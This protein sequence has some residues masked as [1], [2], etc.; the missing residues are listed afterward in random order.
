MRVTTFGRYSRGTARTVGAQSR[1]RHH[2][3]SRT[4]R[5]TARACRSGESNFDAQL[6]LFD[7]TAL[8][9][10]IVASANRAVFQRGWVS[11][12]NYTVPQRDHQQVW[13]TE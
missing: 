5:V 3:R 1:R 13:S 6:D 9:D 4:P 7:N 12:G 11:R 8:A 10:R 2:R